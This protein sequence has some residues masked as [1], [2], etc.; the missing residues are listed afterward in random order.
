MLYNSLLP[1]QSDQEGAR[2]IETEA[3]FVHILDSSRHLSF[4]QKIQSSSVACLNLE[5][6][7]PNNNNYFI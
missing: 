1:L 4:I 3:G 6:H 5:F 7:S 2:N